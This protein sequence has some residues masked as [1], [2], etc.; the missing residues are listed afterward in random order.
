MQNFLSRGGR[1]FQLKLQSPNVDLPLPSIGFVYN[2]SLNYWILNK[3]LYIENC[4]ARLK[5]NENFLLYDILGRFSQEDGDLSKAIENYTA[6][7]VINPNSSVT[8]RNLGSTYH[9]KGDL[10][11]AFASYQKVLELDPSGNNYVYINCTNCP[12]IFS[13]SPS[14]VI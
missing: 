1:S 10:S 11:L 4:L 3:D 14:L 12:V 5:N 13:P 9:Q 6:A 2:A 8:F 7:L